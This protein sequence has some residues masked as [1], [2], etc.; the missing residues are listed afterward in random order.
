MDP[1]SNKVCKAQRRQVLSKVEILNILR[2]QGQH[3]FIPK[4]YYALAKCKYL[5]AA[6]NV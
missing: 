2:I 1:H 6:V 5:S 4:A 3:D